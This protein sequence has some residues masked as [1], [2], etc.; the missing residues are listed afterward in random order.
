MTFIISAVIVS[1]V[2]ISMVLDHYRSKLVNKR[3][4]LIWDIIKEQQKVNEIIAKLLSNS[5]NDKMP[6]L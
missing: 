3:I 6:K 1:L 2:L 4:D 5:K